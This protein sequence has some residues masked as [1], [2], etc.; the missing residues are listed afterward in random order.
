M[1]TNEIKAGELRI[2]NWL[3]IDSIE[4]QIL[5]IGL[6]SLQYQSFN[7]GVGEDWMERIIEHFKPIPLTEELLLRLGF[8]ENGDTMQ[9]HVEN[10]IV[11]FNELDGVNFWIMDTDKVIRCKFVHQL[12]NVWFVHK[13]Q[14]LTL[15]S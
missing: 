6:T 11:S 10:Q 1:K 3:L 9:F 15:K 8:I 13:G 5:S 2:G 4:T 12:Q 7:N 14:E